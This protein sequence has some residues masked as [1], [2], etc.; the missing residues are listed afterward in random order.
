[1]GGVRRAAA[2]ALACVL[3]ALAS[4]THVNP[5]YDPAKPHHRPGGFTNPDAPDIPAGFS[6]FLKWQIERRLYGPPRL[7][8]VPAPVVAPDLAFLRAN[9]RAP[10]GAQVPAVT[11]IGHASVLA[12]LGGLNVLT[13]PQFSE[14]AFPVQWLGPARHQAPGVAL[15]DLPHID[16]VVVSHNHY[17]HLDEASVKALAAQPGG[18]PMFVVPLGVE[19][20]FAEQGIE[21]VTRLDWWEALTVGGVEI[22]LVPVRHW[23]AR[24]LTDRRETLW[25][26]YALFADDCHL[27]FSG[28]TGYGPDFRAVRERFA[29]RQSPALGGGFDVALMAIGAYEPRWFMRNQH[30]NPADAVQAHADLGA[31]RSLGVHWGTFHLADEPLDRPPA[32]LAQARASAGLAPEDFFVLAIGETRRLPRRTAAGAGQ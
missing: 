9:A 15:A 10:R 21:R 22:H 1:M 19:R 24:S 32:E 16:V 20:W 4:C 2:L 6:A 26:G 28:D 11:W 7:D 3:A 8:G 5:D 14:R 30:L 17:D 18:S 13:D 23:S 31:K 29:A 27:Y 25:G 12:Q